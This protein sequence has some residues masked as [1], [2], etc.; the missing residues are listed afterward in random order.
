MED[1]SVVVVRSVFS[2]VQ[3]GRHS[4]AVQLCLYFNEFG[5]AECLKHNATVRFRCYGLLVF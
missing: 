4:Q 5:Q 3:G 2:E 1:V